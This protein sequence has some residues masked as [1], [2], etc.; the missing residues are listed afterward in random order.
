MRCTA[1]VL[2][3]GHAIF[4]SVRNLMMISSSTLATLTKH[5]FTLVQPLYHPM[6]T[7]QMH[8]P[9]IKLANIF[10]TS[11]GRFLS[12]DREAYVL[13]FCA[14]LLESCAFFYCEVYVNSCKS[15][16]QMSTP[17]MTP[18]RHLPRQRQTSLA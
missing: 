17:H 11:C 8:A 5:T 13:V 6:P 1:L 14:L 10:L 12:M 15:S 16:C 9:K 18:K 3:H 2:G 7:Q 4:F